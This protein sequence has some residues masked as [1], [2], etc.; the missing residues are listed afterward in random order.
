VG[1]P[2]LAFETWVF[3]PPRLYRL[4]PPCRLPMATLK[5]ERVRWLFLW[6]GQRLAACPSPLKSNIDRTFADWSRTM[7]N[8]SM[9]RDQMARQEL[10][11]V[12]IKVN[13]EAAFQCQKHLVRIRMTV[14]MVSLGHDAYTNFVIVDISNGMVVVALRC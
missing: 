7:T 8:A 4:C 9:N 1:G 13:E 3:P 12:I 2:G 11:S 10:D 5:L 6:Q 14:P